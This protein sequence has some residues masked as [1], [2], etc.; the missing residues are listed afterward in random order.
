MMWENWD[1]PRAVL[2]LTLGLG[3]GCCAL[4]VVTIH[5]HFVLL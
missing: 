2:M 1:N 3:A 4:A 5:A